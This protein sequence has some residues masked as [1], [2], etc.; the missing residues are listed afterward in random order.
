ME[1]SARNKGLTPF[2]ALIVAGGSGTRLGGALPKQ[3]QKIGGKAVL[4]HTV[5][6]FLAC[7]GLKE[8]RVVIH[9]SHK[10]LYDDTVSGLN[11]LPPSHSGEDRKYSVINGLNDFFYLRNEDIILVHDAARPFITVSQIESV[12]QAALDKKVA[13]LAIPMADT[14]RHDQGNYVNRKGLWS[15]QTPQGFHYGLLRNAHGTIQGDYTDDTSLVAALGH[16]IEMVEGSRAAFK[17]TTQADMDM[18]QKLVE[19]KAMRIRTGS[20]FDVH[21][22]GEPRANGC[23]RICGIDIPHDRGL[24][25]HSDADVGLHALTDALLG[26]IA[27]GDIGQHFPPSDPQWKGAD[28]ALFLKHAVDMVRARGADISNMDITLICEAPKMGPYRAAMQKRVAEIC[29]VNPDQVGIKATTTE[30]LGFTGRREGIAAQA[31]VTIEVP[32][33]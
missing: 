21:A 32:R 2:Y 24:T 7:P 29:G 16:D 6:T 12:A 8:L 17:I 13:T 20:G 5:E 1:I 28:S 33:G 11:L 4:R 26:A 27:A 3:Y 22:F 31:I 14:L 10:D 19:N 23:V 25:G 9:P 30:Q 18:A 15:I